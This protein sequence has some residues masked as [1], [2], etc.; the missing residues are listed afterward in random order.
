MIRL[1][2]VKVYKH[3]TSSASAISLKQ[4]IHFHLFSYNEIKVDVYFF[5][6]TSLEL[7]SRSNIPHGSKDKVC[8]ESRGCVCDIP[9]RR[10]NVMFGVGVGARML[11]LN[12][13]ME[14]GMARI[15]EFC[16]LWEK[17]SA[18][19]LGGVISGVWITHWDLMG[20]SEEAW[21]V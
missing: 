11:E 1:C 8:Q 21:S 2:Y 16:G 10:R 7:C 15:L 6:L 18:A 19:F 12:R 4:V 5:R 14:N 20:C 17:R 13:K 3:F 9:V